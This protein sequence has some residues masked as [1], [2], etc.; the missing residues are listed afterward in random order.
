MNGEKLNVVEQIRYLGL[1]LN[2]YVDY[3]VVSSS[4]AKASSRALGALISKTIKNKGLPFMT[5]EYLFKT[6]IQPIMEYCSSIWGY[7]EYL[8][9]ETVMHR[10]LKF[11]LGI[12]KLL[13]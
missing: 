10:A 8:K 3:T 12:G 7:K 2:E 4:I 9:I 6:T 5:F 11:F 1:D 13:I